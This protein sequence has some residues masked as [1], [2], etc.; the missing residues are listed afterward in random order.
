MEE[1]IFNEYSIVNRELNPIDRGQPMYVGV[2][3]DGL[4][5]FSATR[6]S[7]DLSRVRWDDLFEAP[8]FQQH[9]TDLF[10]AH[11]NLRWHHQSM[12]DATRDLR[13]RVESELTGEAS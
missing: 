13:R 10:W 8:D 5:A 11:E 3:D 9:F 4:E 6:A 2:N 7:G 12:L 1:R